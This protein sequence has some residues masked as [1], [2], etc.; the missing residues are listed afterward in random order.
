MKLPEIDIVSELPKIRDKGFIKS[1]RKDNTGIGYTLETL[2]GIPENNA[3]EPDFTYNG[4]PVELKTQR[5]HASS[6]I[7]LITKSPIWKPLS[8][9]DIIKKYGYK[10]AK[11]RQGMKV[12][13]QATKFN[14][15]KLKL[16]IANGRL[17]IVHEKDG[18]ICYFVINDLMKKLKKKL[19]ENLL[20]VFA[21]AKREQGVEYFHYI[22]AFLLSQFSEE[23]FKA[24]LAGGLLV[25]EF[26][27]H[28]KNSGTVRDHGSGFRLNKRHLD[29]LYSTS[30]KI[31]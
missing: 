2:L 11:G 19:F 17:N 16:E 15:N 23:Q 6:N 4:I 9:K 28:I 10:D 8:A 12:T 14:P 7:T 3:A 13:I 31:M 21:D 27:M 29:K 22:S 25:F 26:R 24:L 5:S 30:K 18:V 1:L 20:L